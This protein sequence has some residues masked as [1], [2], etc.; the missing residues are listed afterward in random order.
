MPDPTPTTRPLHYGRTDRRVYSPYYRHT[1]RLTARGLLA[2]C[3][4]AIPVAV[5]L[6][7]AYA[8]ADLYVPITFVDAGLALAF[9]AAMGGTCGLVLRWGK[10]RNVPVS[11]ALTAVL[12][13]VA[14]YVCWAAWLCAA[15]DRFQLGGRTYTVAGLAVRPHLL[16]SEVLRINA[17]GT[18]SWGRTSH[19]GPTPDWRKPPC[20]RLHRLTS[21]SGGRCSGGFGPEKLP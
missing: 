10:V 11:L 1:G 14:Y 4:L 16:A 6:A 20:G 21:L 17:R 7:I 19:R 9:G 8:Y 18:W 13:L 12:T 5:V 15:I 3:V 2:T